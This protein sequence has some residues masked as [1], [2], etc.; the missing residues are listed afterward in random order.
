MVG[1]KSKPLGW[2][3]FS[4]YIS[5]PLRL[6]GTLWGRG[7]WSVVGFFEGGVR[8]IWVG[9]RVNMV[10]AM[11]LHPLGLPKKNENTTNNTFFFFS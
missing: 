4:P 11:P 3:G 9:Y 5:K 10:S 7:G 6:S 1:D 8:G 2:S